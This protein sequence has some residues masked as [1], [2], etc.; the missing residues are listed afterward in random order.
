MDES[1]Q[2]IGEGDDYKGK[3]CLLLKSTNQ[4]GY[5]WT[6]PIPDFVDIRFYEDKQK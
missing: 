5:A 3:A 2:L 4:R 6:V 1:A